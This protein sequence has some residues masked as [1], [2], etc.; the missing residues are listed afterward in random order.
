MK[1]N[2]LLILACAAVFASC[3]K[4]QGTSSNSTVYLDLP[5]ETYKYWDAAYN[6]ESSNNKATLGRVL[7]YDQHLSLNNS[8]SCASCHRQANAFADNVALSRG[9]ENKLTGRNSMAIENLQSGPLTFVPT[10]KLSNGTLFWDG[11]ENDIQSLVTKPISNHIEMGIADVSVLPQKLAALPYYKDLF[12]KAFGD[13]NITIDRMTEAMFYFMTAIR[14]DKTRFDAYRQGA[15]QLTALELSGLNLFTGTYNCGNC[16]H[17][18]GFAYSSMDFMDIG[19]DYNGRDKGKGAITGLASDMGRFKIPNLRN[20]ALT[21]PYMH[22]GRFAT[23]D[24]VLEHYSHNIQ[25]DANLDD[26]LK[27]NGQ[28]MRMNITTQDKQAIIAFLN[29]LTDYNM[30]TDPKFSNPFKVN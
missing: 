24:D 15:G 10:G 25:N 7:F 1:K 21:A 18:D 13:E 8:I 3:K 22:D 14:T 6:S 23:L 29:T 4:D 19:L 26:R 30:V 2:I 5:Q 20:V 11:R 17:V 16:H 27:I 28:P 9:Y 12:T